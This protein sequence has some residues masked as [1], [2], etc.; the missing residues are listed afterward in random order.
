MKVHNYH[1]NNEFYL[2]VTG[3][4]LNELCSKL[5]QGCLHFTSCYY[6]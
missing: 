5:K 1:N 6:P 2:L 3:N 4:E